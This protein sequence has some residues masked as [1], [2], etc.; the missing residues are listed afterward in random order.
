MCLLSDHL[1]GKAISGLSRTTMSITVLLLC[2]LINY[3]FLNRFSALGLLRFDVIVLLIHTIFGPKFIL[4]NFINLCEVIYRFCWWMLVDHT[5]LFLGIMVSLFV[6]SL[7]WPCI[8]W[9]LWRSTDVV[10]LDIESRLKRMQDRLTVI[11]NRQDEIL[12]ILKRD[13]VPNTSQAHHE[14]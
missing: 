5:S 13:N 9:S 10:V 4:L 8:S 11:E 2:V 14:E 3:V 7:F 6:V 12:Q 1:L